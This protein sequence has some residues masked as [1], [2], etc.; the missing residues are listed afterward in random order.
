MNSY[1]DCEGAQ[2]FLDDH[3]EPFLRVSYAHGFRHGALVAFVISIVII[4]L[5]LIN[6]TNI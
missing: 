1:N 5:V 2:N 3:M 6:L 4:F